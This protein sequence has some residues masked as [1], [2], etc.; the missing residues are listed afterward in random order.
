VDYAGDVA[1][2]GKKYVDPELFAEALSFSRTEILSTPR[3]ISASSPTSIL[4]PTWR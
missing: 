4:I 1:E 2:D 3:L